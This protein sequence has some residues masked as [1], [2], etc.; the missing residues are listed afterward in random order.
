MLGTCVC[1]RACARVRACVCVCMCV[2]VCV[3]VCVCACVRACVRVC[4]CVCCVFIQPLI[5]A[6]IH[7]P[8]N[9]PTHSLIHLIPHSPLNHSSSNLLTQKLPHSSIYFKFRPFLQ[10]KLEAV[11]L[12]RCSG[13]QLSSTDKCNIMFFPLQMDYQLNCNLNILSSPTAATCQKDFEQDSRLKIQS[14]GFQH[15]SGECPYLSSR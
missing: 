14:S 13:N 11:Y 2:C 15:T 10:S 4:V 5:H 1:V 7:S 6:S 12:Y 8:I 9:Q 3:C